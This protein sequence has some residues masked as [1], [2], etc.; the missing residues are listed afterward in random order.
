[1][2]NIE[3]CNILL[4]PLFSLQPM[5]STDF[6]LLSPQDNLVNIGNMF[7]TYLANAIIPKECIHEEVKLNDFIYALGYSSNDGEINKM[8]KDKEYCQTIEIMKNSK[9]KDFINY[10]PSLSTKCLSFIV[11]IFI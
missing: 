6:L 3:N 4:D 5:P 9:L 10:P 8:P 11:P 1:M 7:S 2:N